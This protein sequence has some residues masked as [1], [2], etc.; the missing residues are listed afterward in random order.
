M[1][2]RCS[3]YFF[4]SRP[5]NSLRLDPLT[6]FTSLSVTVLILLPAIRAT[7]PPTSALPTTASSLPFF[8]SGS[9]TNVLPV[10][11]GT[12]PQP[13][14]LTLSTSFPSVL[15]FTDA[16]AFCLSVNG[17]APGLPY[18]GFDAD[19]SS[20]LHA[21]DASADRVTYTAV[22]P[23]SPTSLYAFEGRLAS[24]ALTVSVS[25]GTDLVAG[26]VLLVDRLLAPTVSPWDPSAPA[27]A[28]QALDTELPAG[29]VGFFGLGVDPDHPAWSPLN[30]ALGLSADSA[31]TASAGIDGFV[32]G[33][34]IDTYQWYPG[35]QAGELH[36]GG[37][38][39][40]RYVGDFVWLDAAGSRGGG[41]GVPIDSLEVNGE[42][43]GLSD[44][45]GVLDPGYD[46]I[47]MPAQAAERFYSKVTNAH[48][49]VADPTRWV[50]PSPAFPRPLARAENPDCPVLHQH[51]QP[52]PQ[53]L[54]L[55]HRPRPRRARPAV[56][57]RPRRRCR[58]RRLPRRR[59][60]LA[61][62]LRG[63]KRRPS[64]PRHRLP[65]GRLCGAVLLPGG[66]VRRPR[67][68]GGLC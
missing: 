25:P 41:W 39:S 1:E 30:T 56:L 8:R 20:T 47:W 7:P 33:L 59:R 23:D 22:D 3:R 43:I 12:P 13:V 66:I 44:Y 42:T 15:L 11:A 68:E 27:A 61:P 36:W 55:A 35:Q 21:D 64:A 5:L 54:W 28:A 63:R 24:D 53:H 9:G 50:S 45:Y 14:N 10:L 60:R 6:M 34:S 65:L 31:T 40:N 38:P 26:P 37:I 4:K 62:R 67:G 29:S 17:Y 46:E 19:D 32:A 16:C 18:P 2:H 48:R 51:L 57:L 52:H 49:S 58:R